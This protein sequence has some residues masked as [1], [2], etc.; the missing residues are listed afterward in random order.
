M[1]LQLRVIEGKGRTEDRS[2]ELFEAIMDLIETTCED[3]SVAT[4]IGTLE[5]AKL[6]VLESVAEE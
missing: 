1:T 5:L 6:A 3:M 4:V 2:A